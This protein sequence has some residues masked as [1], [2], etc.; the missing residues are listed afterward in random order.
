MAKRKKLKIKKVPSYKGG[1]NVGEVLGDA[2]KGFLDY[3]LGW[4]GL[5]DVIKEEDYRSDIGKKGSQIL[6]RANP[7]QSALGSTA[8]NVAGSMGY[9]IP[10]QGTM[11]Y[12][13]TGAINQGFQEP[14]KPVDHFGESQDQPVTDRP[15]YFKR[16]GK[17]FQYANGG[18]FEV[19]NSIEIEGNELEVDKGRVTKDFKTLNSHKKGG[20]QYNPKSGKVII[21]KK[22]RDKYFENYMKEHNK[23]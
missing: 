21:P 6:D 17:I 3:Q 12:S 7:I 13:T 5:G 8:L 19:T 15:R 10:G 18:A 23:C 11:L 14:E 4:F 16:G 1:G 9:G 20:F 2:G 22:D